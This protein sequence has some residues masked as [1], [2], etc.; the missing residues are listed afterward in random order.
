MA[1][2]G[3]SFTR[4]WWGHGSPHR[5]IPALAA[6]GPLDPCGWNTRPGTHRPNTDAKPH[7][8]LTPASSC[9]VRLRVGKLSLLQGR[10]TL[11]GDTGILPCPLSLHGRA[12]IWITMRRTGAL[13]LLGVLTHNTLVVAES[14]PRGVGPECKSLSCFPDSQLQLT[15]QV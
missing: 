11:L 4:P 2:Y 15:L 9:Q 6:V 13:A 10:S 14:L 7:V 1:G 3:V 8:I 12:S 5:M